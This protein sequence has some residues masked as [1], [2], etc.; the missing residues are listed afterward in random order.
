MHKTEAERRRL[1]AAIDAMAV[2]AGLH[3]TPPG[4]DPETAARAGGYTHTEIQQVVREAQAES[5]AEE[6]AEARTEA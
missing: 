1:Y 5:L 2:E 6:I 3:P 4:Y